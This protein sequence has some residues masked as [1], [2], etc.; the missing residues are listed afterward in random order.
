MITTDVYISIQ[1]KD[2]LEK[3]AALMNARVFFH[4]EIQKGDGLKVTIECE[5]A[6]NL[7]YLGRQIEL[8]LEREEIKKRIANH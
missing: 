5:F 4:H 3:V 2:A 6:H 8:H 1:E 7:W